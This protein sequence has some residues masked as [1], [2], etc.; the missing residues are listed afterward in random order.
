MTVLPDDFSGAALRPFWAVWID[1]TGDPVRITTIPGGKTFASTGDPDLDE[2]AYSYLPSELLGVGPVTH[3]KGGSETVTA[4]LCGVPG[5][6][7]ELLAALADRAN[8]QGKICRLWIGTADAAWNVVKVKGYYT[9]YAQRCPLS[10]DPDAGQDFA[11]QIENYLSALTTPRGRTYQDQ[12]DFDP[13][14]VSAARMRAAANG[15]SGAAITGGG[16]GGNGG[17]VRPDIVRMNA[18]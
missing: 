15:T 8:W 18:V 5:P 16:G 13:A 6:N 1:V 3:G 2:I 17:G 10:G 4:T 7:D 9:G 11:L 12:A 14:D